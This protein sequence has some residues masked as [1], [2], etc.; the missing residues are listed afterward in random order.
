[1]DGDP[2]TTRAQAEGQ[3]TM[4]QLPS[5]P[6]F[7]LPPRQALQAPLAT[8]LGWGRALAGPNAD[9]GITSAARQGIIRADPRG[10]F[11][12][13]FLPV[14]ASPSPAATGFVINPAGVFTYL[15]RRVR[16]VPLAPIPHARLTLGK[17][18]M[19]RGLGALS[20]SSR[21]KIACPLTSIPRNQTTS[22]FPCG[23][24][25]S[26]YLSTNSVCIKEESIRTAT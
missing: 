26:M 25:S 18:A 11:T 3:R 1:M 20:R 15:A 19:D 16:P 10:P 6:R 5:N 24:D 23:F 8:A 9:W 2:G 21:L 12:S 22:G 13:A 14:R 4:D 17:V 7:R